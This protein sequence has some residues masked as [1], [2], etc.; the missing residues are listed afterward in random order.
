LPEH[1]LSDYDNEGGWRIDIVGLVE[2]QGSGLPVTRRLHGCLKK[3]Q[4]LRWMKMS[5]YRSS[6]GGH[7]KSIHEELAMSYKS[8][9]VG[10]AFIG[11]EPRRLARRLMGGKGGGLI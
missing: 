9:L 7:L 1:S 6:A 10:A 11:A 4:L 3:W 8:A 2:D 5:R